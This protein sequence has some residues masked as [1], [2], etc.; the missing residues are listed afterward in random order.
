MSTCY[1]LTIIYIYFNF[2]ILTLLIV[3]TAHFDNASCRQDGL[4]LVKNAL[5]WVIGERLGRVLNK[6]QGKC[7]KSIRMRTETV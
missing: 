4:D 7:T 5:G 6:L 2:T 1:I 3:H